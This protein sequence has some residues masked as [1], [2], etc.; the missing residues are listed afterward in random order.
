MSAIAVIG[1][2]AFGTALAIALS[3]TGTPVTLVAR[4][5]AR[6]LDAARENSRYLPGLP[7]PAGLRV[8]AEVPEAAD[9]VLL[10]VP[11]Q[12]LARMFADHAEM[13]AGQRLV[14][15]CK[16]I[17]LATGLGPATLASRLSPGSTCAI[18]TGPS[19]AVDIAQ[20]LPTALT[21]ACANPRAGAEIQG[22]LARPALRIYLTD[23]VIGAELGGALKNVVALA[24]GLTI[25]AGLGESARASVVTR[26]FAEMQRAAGAM[27]ARSETLVGLSGL[28]DLL[29]TATSEKSRNFS[30]GIRLGRG[31]RFDGTS[32]VEGIATAEAM[33]QVAERIGAELPLTA[34]VAEVTSGRIGVEEARDILLARPLRRE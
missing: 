29:L 12:S 17:D 8:A 16:G 15:C 11:M 22:L 25:G 5:A 10:A 34:M 33:L 18:L 2:G 4:K 6:E 31:G 20:G 32:T 14:A 19:F 1:A 21:L 28:G 3:S 27:G 24:A 9:L 13:L 26:G 7:F 23:D 30:T